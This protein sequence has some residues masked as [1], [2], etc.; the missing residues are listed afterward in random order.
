MYTY[1]IIPIYEQIIICYCHSPANFNKM[2]IYC[3]KPIQNM[4]GCLLSTSFKA[5]KSGLNWFLSIHL[6]YS[7]VPKE[8]G[9]GD[10]KQ[11]TKLRDGGGA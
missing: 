3:S 2:F 5:K 7:S 9:G 10:P 1:N 11:Y 6:I 4:L 8:R